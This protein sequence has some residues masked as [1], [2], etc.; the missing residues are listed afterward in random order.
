MIDFSLTTRSSKEPQS[1]EHPQGVLFA[2]GAE[3]IRTLGLLNAI[4]ARSQLRH[5]PTFHSLFNSG[6]ITLPWS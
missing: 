3:G 2:G 1:K 6:F 5:S 4:E